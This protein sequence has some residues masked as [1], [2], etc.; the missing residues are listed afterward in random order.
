MPEKELCFCAKDDDCKYRPRYTQKCEF[1]PDFQINR[2]I[3]SVKKQCQKESDCKSRC[4]RK[5]FWSK[6]PECDEN[7]KCKCLRCYEK[8]DCKRVC[9]K[10]ADFK[11]DKTGF[12]NC[13]P[14]TP[15]RKECSIDD[16]CTER[17]WKSQKLGDCNGGK[18]V[19]KSCFGDSDCRSLC[20]D[21]GKSKAKCD[22]IDG[23]CQCMNECNVH[24]D[25]TKK[26]RRKGKLGA[27]KNGKC[28]CLGCTE[29]SQ[30]KNLC[31]DNGKPRYTCKKESGKCHCSNE[32]INDKE[33]IERCRLI[34]KL[35]ACQNGQC[36][37]NSC[38]RQSDCKNLCRWLGKPRYSCD[39]ESGQCKCKGK[40]RVRNLC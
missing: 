17:C 2:C 21:F 15:I 23:K 4:Q 1:D 32:C 18:C 26:C 7:G 3:Y 11:C 25:C 13:L 28:R 35:G 31:K 12:C 38:S 39:E 37:C 5:R 16:D 22:K 14:I 36:A 29:H 24:K 34:G 19:C 9:S 6:I 20:K 40:L 33:C 8:M 30:C 27:C 10:T